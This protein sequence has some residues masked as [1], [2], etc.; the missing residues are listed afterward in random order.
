MMQRT[1]DVASAFLLTAIQDWPGQ[2]TE[3]KQAATTAYLKAAGFDVEPSGIPVFGAMFP[4]QPIKGPDG[5]EAFDWL[6]RTL[7]SMQRG[8]YEN[9]V[10][11]LS[12]AISER[13]DGPMTAPTEPKST[14]E[15]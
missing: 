12:R 15:A 10:E 1:K 13:W 2:T 8:K 6:R 5:K 9:E 3:Q 4:Q 11:H 7:E 14:T